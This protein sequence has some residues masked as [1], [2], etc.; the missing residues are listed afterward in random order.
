M[1]NVLPLMAMVLMLTAC[2]NKDKKM[3]EGAKK[4]FEDAVALRKD[5]LIV[6]ELKILG[7]KGLNERDID[8]LRSTAFTYKTMQYQQML[9]QYQQGL[10][11]LIQDLEKYK[12]EGNEEMVQ[13]ANM[14][15]QQMMNEATGIRDSITKFE[16][17]AK[18]YT[19]KYKASK[20]KELDYTIAYFKS[21][22]LAG[23]DS[24]K[25]DSLPLIFTKEYKVLDVNQ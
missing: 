8:S 16:A 13:Q 1:K 25:V 12:K 22:L 23:K 9:M 20:A 17:K 19:E 15:G 11:Q 18:E 24:L 10:Q 7:S 14:Y 3:T 4:Y 21:N 6:K 5:T 2:N